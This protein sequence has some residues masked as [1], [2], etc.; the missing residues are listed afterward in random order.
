[1]KGVPR[2]AGPYTKV[3]ST[4]QELESLCQI[5][6]CTKT[7]IYLTHH[8]TCICNSFMIIRNADELFAACLD[9][10][11]KLIPETMRL[12]FS[13][14]NSNLAVGRTLFG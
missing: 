5:Q 13:S 10:P 8:S 14:G 6:T 9:M 2:N 12:E 7:C 3:V 11:R 4:N 1:M